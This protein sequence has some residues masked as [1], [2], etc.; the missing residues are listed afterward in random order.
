MG[1]QFQ[2]GVRGVLAA[3]P[4][5][6][7]AAC[8]VVIHRSAD[9]CDDGAGEPAAARPIPLHEPKLGKDPSMHALAHDLDH[10]EKH[11]DWHGSVVAKTPDVWGQAR[12]TQY[13]EEFEKEMAG[14]LNKFNAGIQGSVAR[15]DQAFFSSSLA[16]SMA[17]QP[18]P[19]VI[20]TTAPRSLAPTARDTVVVHDVTSTAAATA[21][22]PATTTKDTTTTTTKEA[23]PTP[24]SPPTPVTPLPLANL[25][26][27]MT[28]L[29]AAVDRNKAELTKL[30]TSNQL[31]AGIGIEP[32]LLL[33]QKKRYLDFLNQLRRE[34]EGDDTADSPGYSLNLIRVPVSVLPG[35]HTDKGHGAEITMTLSPILGDDLLPMTMRNFVINDLVDQLGFSI[36]AFLDEERGKK[37]EDRFLTEDV[38][39]FLQYLE[40]K[41]LSGIPTLPQ[42]NKSAR[43]TPTATQSMARAQRGFEKFG[44][45]ADFNTVTMETLDQRK[46][47]YTARSGGSA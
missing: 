38:Q 14:E 26:A 24:G 6:S 30:T 8:Q 18:K 21:A 10:L 2:T 19:P 31:A 45:T 25:N 5:L 28:E 7:L 13:R 11:L 1:G 15:T 23:V 32:T 42:S 27:E 9:E 36:T 40:A 35:T 20:G 39:V 44:T 22:A 47:G 12:L 37:A 41:N 29:K 3:L 46:P 4:I 33:A 16:L 17:A 34:N 43:T